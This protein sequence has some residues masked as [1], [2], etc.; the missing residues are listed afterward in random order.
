MAINV[1]SKFAIL[2]L[3]LFAAAAVLLSAA[4]SARA[5][6][7]VSVS[8]DGHLRGVVSFVHSGDHF[9][10]CDKRK[11]NL[12]VGVRYAYMR[13]DDTRQTGAHWHT[14][15]VDGRGNPNE[16]GTQIYG[17][18]YGEHDFAEGSNL[19]FQACVRNTGGALTCSRTQVTSTG[20]K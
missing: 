16:H 18:S 13:K 12:P 3:T 7:K 9:T 8:L 14:V 20:P 5:D 15:G 10:V 19:W 17:C 6:A 1:S 4:A 2:A 11:D